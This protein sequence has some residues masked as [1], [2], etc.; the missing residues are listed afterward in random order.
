MIGLGM[1]VRWLM[2]HDGSPDQRTN[3]YFAMREPADPSDATPDGKL[4]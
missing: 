1:L 2:I 4:K 3:G